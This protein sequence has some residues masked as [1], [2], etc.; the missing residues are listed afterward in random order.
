MYIGAYYRPHI[1]DE[2]SFTQLDLSLHHLNQITNNPTILLTGDF[3]LTSIDWSENL[4]KHGSPFRAIH[5][6]SLEIL[7]DHGLQQLVTFPTRESNTLDLV[8]TNKPSSILNI[9][10]AAG[11][12]DHDII[13]FEVNT[14]IELT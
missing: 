3:N 1:N 7:Q 8:S 13:R 4:V 12:S 2:Y 10:N 5:E 9:E 6:Y 14:K 11:I